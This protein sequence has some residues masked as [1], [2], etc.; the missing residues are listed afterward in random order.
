MTIYLL[1]RE[2]LGVVPH[3]FQRE[4][5]WATWPYGRELKMFIYV[6]LNSLIPNFVQ[7]AIYLLRRGALGLVAPLP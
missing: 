3:P 4:L 7:V 1:R 2:A 6:H 5:L